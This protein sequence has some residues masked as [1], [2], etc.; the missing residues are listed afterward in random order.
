VLNDFQGRLTLHMELSVTVEDPKSPEHKQLATSPVHDD[1]PDGVVSMRFSTPASITIRHPSRSP[2][3]DLLEKKK[4]II[5]G[6]SVEEIIDTLDPTVLVLP[7]SEVHVSDVVEIADSGFVPDPFDLGI[8]A[9]L[10]RRGLADLKPSKEDFLGSSSGALSESDIVP[11]MDADVAV[12]AP[13]TPD[14][15]V[16]QN[17][18]SDGSSYP[19]V[20]EH[21][22]PDAA[23][24]FF[25][26]SLPDCE[27]IESD[28]EDKEA[29]EPNS[30]E[31]A[32]DQPSHWGTASS[33][34][35]EVVWKGGE[36]KSAKVEAWAEKAFNEWRVFRGHSTAQSI[37]DLSEEAHAGPLVDLLVQYFLELKRRN[38]ELYNPGT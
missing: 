12:T 9:D 25:R 21:L 17:L 27:R 20:D 23:L 26:P 35:L 22:L 10:R 24:D 3:V 37:A 15:P 31:T 5:F 28:P 14:I 1:C 38:G 36:R 7:G 13:L 18:T 34:D 16:A 2:C 8:K 6:G 32:G 29:D 19:P 4:R 11:E 30:L 33:E